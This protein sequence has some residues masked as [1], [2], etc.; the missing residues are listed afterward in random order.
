MKRINDDFRR[1][2][3]AD[4][5]IDVPYVRGQNCQVNN[6]WHFCT[7]GAAVDAMFCDEEDFV[8]G[9]N[10]I[11]VVGKKYWDS[12]VI[13]AF[14]LM[15]THVHFVLYGRYDECN[16][17]IHEYLRLTSLE[18]SRRHKVKKNLLNIPV[19]CQT[20]DDDFYLRVVICYVV[21]NAPV[22]GLNFNA[23]DYPWSSGPLYFRQ[24][25]RWSSPAWMNWL[26]NERNLSGM[27][28]RYKRSLLKTRDVQIADDAIVFD[29]MV[30][31]GEYVAYDIVERIFKT[32]RG[33]N[34][35]MCIS[36]D[37]DVDQRGGIISRLSIPI[38]ELRQ[39]RNEISMELFGTSS[40]KKLS[41]QQRLKLARA[42]RRRYN[43][44]IKQI[45]RICGLI[46]EE[47]KHQ[48]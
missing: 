30:F 8:S 17:F 21:K 5:S 1:Q 45:I 24:K 48:L 9:M 22:G 34:F 19:V 29:G 11:Y 25:D 35:F 2:L 47:A 28:T 20:V 3:Y 15:D 44:S 36:K 7:D 18:I 14:S 26:D 32:H 13:L 33:F 37:D 43:S 23:Y 16:C 40:L 38:Y 12:V 27:G 39:Y 41:V 6:C 46:Y 4:L 42:L 31:P 10:R